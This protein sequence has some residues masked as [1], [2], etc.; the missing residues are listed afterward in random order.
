MELPEA[1]NV[2]RIFLLSFFLVLV[3]S[4]IA[5]SQ[6][7][8]E[9]L[10]G[11]P[12][13]LPFKLETGYVG[14][15]EMD[16]VQ[17]FYYF[18]ESERDPQFDPLLL[19]LTGGPGCSGF[20]AIAFEIG[21]V[22]I[23]TTSFNG[24]LPSLTLNPYSWTKVASIIFIDAPVGTGFSY[25]TTVEGAN[26]SDTI[27]AAQIYT[28]LRKW[29]YQHPQFIGHET[30][31]GGDS[32]SGITIPIVVTNILEGL[33]AGLN[34]HIDLQGYIIG[35]PVTDNYIDVNERIPYLHRVSIISDAYYE[36][37]KLQCHGDYV[38][39]DYNNTLCVTAMQNIKECY[40]QI[41]LTQILEPQCAFTK[42]KEPQW[43]VR[44]QEANTQDYLDANKLPELKC[45]EFGYALSYKYM[46][47]KSVQK[48][49]NVREGTVKNWAR[50]LKVFPTYTENINSTVDYHKNLSNTGMRALIYSGDHDI[51]VPYLATLTWIRLLDV[52]IFDEWRPWYVDGQVAGYQTKYM[53]DYYRLT[54]V[55]LKGAGHTAPEFK[56]KQALA[57]V[58]RFF[59]RYPI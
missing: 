30:Y 26:S 42:P 56:P 50:C 15:G 17:F 10:P 31:I 21:P 14:V 13:K 9:S 16:E 59:A 53:N 48:A 4:H 58:D 55:T 27:N 35:N 49:L 18:F 12:G 32:Y 44:S 43:D 11:L 37:A 7:I 47:D 38:N 20:S 33:E 6:T 25:S 57:M 41:K 54:Y 28:F 39:I 24:G 51:S 8:V 2:S 34:P 19:W 52:P 40:L 5:A 29:M 36:A 3:F 1:G 23:N 46:N 45:R 22:G